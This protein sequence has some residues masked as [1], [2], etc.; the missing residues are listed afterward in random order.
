MRVNNL[1]A[2][3]RAVGKRFFAEGVFRE[4]GK[5]YKASSLLIEERNAV[6]QDPHGEFDIFLVHQ[7]RDRSLVANFK[8][9]LTDRGFR[10]YTNWLHDS[11]LGRSQSILRTKTAMANSRILLYMHTHGALSSRWTAWEIGYFDALKNCQA[12]GVMPFLNHAGLLPHYGGMEFLHSYTQ[13][14]FEFLETFVRNG[15]L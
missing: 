7:L 12:I 6:I 14:G 9:F 4:G 11:E 1:A 2:E 13:I 15:R 3:I 8:R 5:L 10:V